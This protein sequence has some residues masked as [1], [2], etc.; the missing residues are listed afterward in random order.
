MGL[1]F[2]GKV[3]GKFRKGKLRGSEE[4]LRNLNK[5]IGKIE[6]DLFNALDLA[7]I[8]IKGRAQRITPV[9]KSFLIGSAFSQAQRLRNRV[10]ARIGYTIKYAPWVHEMPATTNW[11]KEGAE[12]KFLEKAVVRNVAAILR[13]IRRHA[14]R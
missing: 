8:F 13:L 6:G 11:Q 9:D 10:V 3:G 14:K 12:N 7:A 2:R 5:E 1:R 4:I